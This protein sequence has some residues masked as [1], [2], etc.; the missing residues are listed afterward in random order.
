MNTRVLP[1][2]S[3]RTRITEKAFVWRRSGRVG[4]VGRRRVLVRVESPWFRLRE[5]PGPFYRRHSVVFLACV[6]HLFLV[7]DE[8][9][10][11]LLWETY[12]RI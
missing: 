10:F 11:P 3:K 7:L 12:S 5:Y 4:L 9:E 2:Y 1:K 6:K 8:S